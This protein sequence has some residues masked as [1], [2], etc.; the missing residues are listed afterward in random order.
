[1]WTVGDRVRFITPGL[2]WTGM[3]GTVTGIIRY[4]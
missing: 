1:M 2:E 4:G 3:E